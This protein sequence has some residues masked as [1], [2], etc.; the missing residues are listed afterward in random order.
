MESSKLFFHIL[1]KLPEAAWRKTIRPVKFCAVFKKHF[2]GIF[3]AFSMKNSH[4]EQE[5][6][7]NRRPAGSRGK[8]AAP[9]GFSGVSR[10]WEASSTEERMLAFFR[11]VSYTKNSV[12][13]AEDFC[14]S[15]SGGT[16]G[17]KS[18]GGEKLSAPAFCPAKG[19]RIPAMRRRTDKNNFTA[20]ETAIYKI[21]IK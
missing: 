5:P 19:T 6:P 13:P 14:R 9:G 12:A 15:G 11:L 16:G 7:A 21:L 20:A 8:P 2:R 1:H 17:R 4:I 18:R 3:P 10:G